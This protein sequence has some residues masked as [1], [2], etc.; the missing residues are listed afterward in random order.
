MNNL[1]SDFQQAGRL[2]DAIELYRRTLELRLAK[3]GA[4]HPH[5]M[6]TMNSLAGA[7]LECKEW[8]TAENLL[9]RCLELRAKSQFGDWWR[10]H[11]MSQLGAALVGQNRYTEA[12][13]FLISG[14]EGLRTRETQ[15]PAPYK[16]N[17]AAAAARVVPFYEAWR[18]VDKAAEWRVKLANPSA[19]RKR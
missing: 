2:A 9:R 15:I 14:F 16:K 18:K 13:P 3:L 1:A 5:T 4:P 19:E 6:H 12:E 10:F 17:L 11:T 7:Y 8:S